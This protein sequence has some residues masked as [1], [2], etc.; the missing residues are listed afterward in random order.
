MV[1]ANETMP[2][3]EFTVVDVEPTC[4]D[5]AVAIGEPHLVD[6]RGGGCEVARCLVTG[7]QRVMCQADHDDCG[8][9][10]WTGRW[11]GVLECE[12]FGWM[13]GPDFPDL[14]RLY[15]EA[16]WDPVRFTWVKPR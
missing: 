8:L 1:D 4:P 11:P 9:D 5:C 7:L 14:N 15:G 12:Q 13:L 16:T 2:G 10:L 3:N 6:G